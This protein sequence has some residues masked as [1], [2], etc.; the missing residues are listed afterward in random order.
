[1]DDYEIEYQLKRLHEEHRE[2]DETL[3]ALEA[4]AM[5]DMMEVQRLKKR[6]LAIK[7]QIATLEAMQHP[8]I[9]A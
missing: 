6:K 4:K 1:M 3:H 2:L 5:V 7:D 8:D 9:I